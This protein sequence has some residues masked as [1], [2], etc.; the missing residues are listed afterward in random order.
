[1][2]YWTLFLKT[3]TTRTKQ[4]HQKPNNCLKCFLLLLCSFNSF[5]ASGDFCCLLITFADSLSPDQAQQNVGPDLD[6]NCLTLWWYSWEIFFEKVNFEKK[7]T[8][9]KK[10]MQS[11]PACK[12]LRVKTFFSENGAFE[13]DILQDLSLRKLSHTCHPPHA[14]F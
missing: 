8:D 5:P 3:S 6:P 11:Y 10:G 13:F 4:Q 14:W 7:S 2:K 12:E 1:M 9:D